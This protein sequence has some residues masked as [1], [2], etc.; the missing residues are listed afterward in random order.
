MMQN[1]VKISIITVG[2]NHR[3][4][5]EVL[6]KTLYEDCKPEFEF[7]AI[8]IDNCS[9]DDSVIFVSTHYP[10]VKVVTNLK[11]LGFGENNNKGVEISNGDYFCLLNPDIIL[12]KGSLEKVIIKAE[13]MDWKGIIVPKL[14]NIDGSVQ[15]SVRGFVTLGT[16][17][18]RW[19]TWEND[20]TNNSIV[21]KYLC[22]DLDLSKEQEVDWAIGAAMF[23][24]RE[25]YVGLGG[26]DQ[27]YFLYMEDEDL[28]LRAWEHGTPVLY[29]PDAEFIHHH[30]RGSTHLGK[31]ALQHLK[32]LMTFFHLHGFNYKRVDKTL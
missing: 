14:L 31:R 19:L 27:R 15:N 1:K 26:F 24:S 7:E 2:M 13:S 28:C 21:R 18:N 30:L 16:I 23:M 4:Y 8:Y 20:N 11:P 12:R 9:T 25:T 22:K 10:Q 17:L 29:Y 3:K 32:S 6:Y 5:I